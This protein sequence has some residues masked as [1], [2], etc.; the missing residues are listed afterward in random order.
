MNISTLLPATDNSTSIHYYFIVISEISK[1]TIAK[2]LYFEK[3]T[4]RQ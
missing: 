1:K 2:H 4:N 3:R